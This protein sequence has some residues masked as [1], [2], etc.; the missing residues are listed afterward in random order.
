MKLIQIDKFN[1]ASDF[2]K[3]S[4]ELDPF[5]IFA[6]AVENCKPLLKIEKISR[7]GVLYQVIFFDG[8]SFMNGLL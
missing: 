2:E 4:I 3:D 8:F 1:K 5:K 6:K 7:G